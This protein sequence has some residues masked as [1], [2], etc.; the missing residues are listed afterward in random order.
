MINNKLKNIS[1]DRILFISIFLIV[2]N[3]CCDSQNNILS[4]RTFAQ[5][6]IISPKPQELL[7][8]IYGDWTMTIFH[9]SGPRIN[10]IIFKQNGDSTLLYKMTTAGDTLPPLIVKVAMNNICWEESLGNLNTGRSVPIVYSG[11]IL[12]DST[13]KGTVKLQYNEWEWNAK[14][15]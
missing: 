5:D 4:A 13:I 3:L 6:S 11:I 10:T 8:N 1:K 9:P 15:Q 2:S 7:R 12:S 14:K